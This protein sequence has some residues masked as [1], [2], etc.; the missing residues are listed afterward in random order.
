MFWVSY[1]SCQQ[2]EGST[3]VWLAIFLVLL[4]A[5]A[6]A[7]GCGQRGNTDSGEGFAIYLL[8]REV[9]PQAVPVLSHLELAETPL[10]SL[11][12]IVSYEKST[13]RIK[14]NKE[15]SQRVQDVAVPVRGRVFVVCVD[16]QLVYW[17]A[18]WTP[19]S[20]Q[21]WDGV[22]IIKPLGAQ[23]AIQIELGYPGPDFF[24]GNDPRPDPKVLG[25]L[26]RAGK[27]R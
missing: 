7:G 9:P 21:S 4:A 18:F 26:E 11:K 22:T 14:L 15:A 17:G 2:A 19:I 3:K 25:S 20:S 12:D 6:P 24:R 23:D 5:I 27:L 13:H 10:I 1:H 16:R 8:A